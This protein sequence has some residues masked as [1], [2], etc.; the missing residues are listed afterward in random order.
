MTTMPHN[1]IHFLYTGSDVLNYEVG[2]SEASEQ[3]CMEPFQMATI[4]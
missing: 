4:T 3:L 2:L 1:V